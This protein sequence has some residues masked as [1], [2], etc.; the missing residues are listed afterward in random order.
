MQACNR[1]TG[2]LGLGWVGMW[3]EGTGEPGAA[4]GLLRWWGRS[5]GMDLVVTGA[6]V[7]GAGEGLCFEMRS[8]QGYLCE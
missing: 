4:I 2:G 8:S 7:N 1:I 5:Y 3:G 6:T